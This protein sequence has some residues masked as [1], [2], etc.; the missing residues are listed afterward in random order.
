MASAI[1]QSKYPI[2]GLVMSLKGTF[3]LKML[4]VDIFYSTKS[5]ES[6]GR[7]KPVQLFSLR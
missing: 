3:E 1:Q 6:Q 4:N 2:Y 5:N 7:E